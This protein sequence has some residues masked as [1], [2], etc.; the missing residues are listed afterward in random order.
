M[1]ICRAFIHGGAGGAIAPPLLLN[2]GQN[3]LCLPWI[4]GFAPP[5]LAYLKSCHPTFGQLRNA[6]ILFDMILA[7]IEFKNMF[8]EALQDLVRYVI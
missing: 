5:L 2:F 6:L 7:N 8:L 4:F 3:H 1:L